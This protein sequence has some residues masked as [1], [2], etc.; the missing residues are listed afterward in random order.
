[1]SI[2]PFDW[3]DLP[4]LHRYRNQSV[5]LHT[6]LVL[7]RGPMM[8]SGALLSSLAPAMG[9]YTSVSTNNGEKDAFLV[10]QII[11]LPGAQNSQ[12]TFLEAVRSDSTIPWPRISIFHMDEYVGIDPAHPASFPLFLRRQLI[13][14]IQPQAFYPIQASEAEVERTL[15]EYEALLR[16]HP[17]DLCVL[18]IGENGHLAFN[19]PP[20]ADFQDPLW[21]KVVK[22]DEASRRQQ[23]GEGHFTRLEEVPTHAITLTIPALLASRRVLAVVPERRKAVAVQRALQGP[24]STD[25][26]ASILRQCEHALLFL[27]RESASLLEG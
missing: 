24:M 8:I 10:G 7:T 13:Q 4:A 12:L 22:L 14:H 27:D 2:R 25:C 18:G 6:S 20:F 1:M 17:A 19:D 16:S 5:F 11:H 3:R 26:P 21:V 23:V 9:I 15:R